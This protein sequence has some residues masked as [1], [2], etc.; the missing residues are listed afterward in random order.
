MPFSRLPPLDQIAHIQAC[1]SENEIHSILSPLLG[2]LGVDQYFFLS[3]HRNKSSF[4]PVRYALLGGC[5]PRMLHMY[6][7]RR[8][9]V[10][11]PYVQH[12]QHS[13]WPVTGSQLGT[14]SR[15]QKEML[16]NDSVEGFRS[17]LAV[18]VQHGPTTGAVLR[19]GSQFT[20]SQGGEERL[21]ENSVLFIALANVLLNKQL[22]LV[23]HRAARA[24]QLDEKELS[25]LQLLSG[26]H[27]ASVIAARLDL[28]PHTVNKKYRTISEKLQVKNVR[29]AIQKAALVGLVT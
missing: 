2:T 24:F 11:D 5:N 19:L 16:A 3:I 4:E 7:S 10:N 1:C 27:T 17:C 15:G 14:L 18:P 23:Q 6:W 12:A 13:A 20:P 26:N 21:Q 9:F 8:W 22:N 28:S 29:E 25:I